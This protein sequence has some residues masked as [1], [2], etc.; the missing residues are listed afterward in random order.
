[1]NKKFI[2]L[3]TVLGAALLPL[4]APVASAVKVA[5]LTYNIEL[6][7]GQKKKGFVDVTN[8][9]SAKTTFTFS[10]QALKQ[11]NAAGDLQFYDDE[12]VNAGIALDYATYDIEPRATLHLAFIA[13]SAKLPSGDSFAVIFAIATPRAGAGSAGVRVGTILTIQNGTP[14][15]HKAEITDI[16]VPFIQIGNAIK[17]SYSI[18]NTSDPQ[19]STGFMPQV[20]L[21]I[22]PFHQSVQNQASLVFAGIERQ[23]NFSIQSGRFG[24]YK[25]T[26]TFGDSNKETWVF[27]ATP[28]GIVICIG[29]VVTAVLGVFAA[30]R[31]VRSRRT[32]GRQSAKRHSAEVADNEIA[33][34]HG[35]EF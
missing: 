15:E 4:F 7:S 10:V 27:C 30:I 25:V 12:K 13:D 2:L 3:A 1:M 17:G 14:A 21:A 8:T 32:G 31:I 26:A 20:E 6:A 23:N 19:K 9:D 16:E 33:K 24:F 22:D 34:T 18:K 28:L 29:I 35:R 5:P 11:I